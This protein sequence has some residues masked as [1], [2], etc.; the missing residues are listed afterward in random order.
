M[1]FVKKVIRIGF[2]KLKDVDSDTQYHW[3]VEG[4]GFVTS[5]ETGELFRVISEDKDG[6]PMVIEEL[7]A[8]ENRKRRQKHPRMNMAFY[9]DNLAYLKEVAWEN[10]K[11]ITQY[12]NDLIEK[13]R[14]AR[15]G[16]PHDVVVELG[17]RR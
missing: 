13:D 15:R 16:E 10:K 9:G 12:V 3:D 17:K 8:K 14:V 5:L 4:N 1:E 2:D 6:N 7:T 11:S